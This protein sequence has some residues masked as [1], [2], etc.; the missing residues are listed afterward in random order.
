[1]NLPSIAAVVAVHSLVAQSGTWISMAQAQVGEA[2]IIDFPGARQTTTLGINDDGVIVGDYRGDDG[3]FHGFVL[4][5]SKF[6]STPEP[7][8]AT[9]SSAAAINNSI[10][11]VG[12][13]VLDGI[14]HGFLFN[15]Y[16]Q[17]GF[18]TVDVPV[19]DAILTVPRGI[20]ASGVIVGRFDTADGVTHGFSLDVDSQD[21]TEINFPG[22]STTIA[23][24]INADGV[25]VGQYTQGG[26]TRGFALKA[27]TFTT[28]EPPDST[29]SN[30]KGINNCGYIGGRYTTA[31]NV[32][33]A[34]WGRLSGPFTTYDLSR[35]WTT[36]NGINNDGYVVG[37]F[38]DDDGFEH[39][40]LVAAIS[41]CG[42]R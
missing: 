6:S 36:V 41:G 9:E 7:N 32:I 28:I 31:D 42:P 40:F 30:W 4:N 16:K 19:P 29:T 3:L 24:G 33:H 21:F 38:T 5:D 14:T 23:E 15:V 12:K 34:A 11:I 35:T 17:V 25:V 39:G 27:G 22:A 18:R 8:G 26:V 10:D 37:R 2:E 20:S 1:M 13:Y